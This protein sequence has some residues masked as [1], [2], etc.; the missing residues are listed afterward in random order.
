MQQIGDPLMT[1]KQILQI[2]LQALNAFEQAY[3][4]RVPFSLLIRREWDRYGYVRV[5]AMFMA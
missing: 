5:P 1:K 3:N 4:D 2:R